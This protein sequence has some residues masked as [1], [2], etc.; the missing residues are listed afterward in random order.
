MG[1]DSEN[2]L[3]KIFDLVGSPSL[4]DLHSMKLPEN[5]ISE[6]MKMPKKPKKSLKALFPTADPSVIDLLQKLLTFNPEKRFTV[7]QALKH[8]YM[9]GLSCPED[10]VPPFLTLFYFFKQPVR[11]HVTKWDFEFEDYKLNI[12]QIKGIL[13]KQST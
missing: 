7:E 13:P 12:Q 6:L 1:M 5:Q 3:A 10:E 4:E 2:Q 9:A 8:P 11:E